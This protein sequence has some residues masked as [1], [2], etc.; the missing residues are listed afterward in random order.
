MKTWHPAAPAIL[1]AFHVGA[2]TS[3]AAPPADAHEYWLA[4]SRYDAGPGAALTVGG[5]A[6]TGFRGERKPWSPTHGVRFVV[7]ARATLDLRG[8]A[9]VGEEA[10]ARFAPSDRGGAL[11]GYVSDFTPV[12]LDPGAFDRY[13][14]DE[15][16]SLAQAARRAASARGAGARPGLERYRRCAKAWIAGDDAARATTPLGFPLEIV[17]GTIPGTGPTLDLRV[18]RDGRPAAGLLVKA[19]RAPLGGDGTPRADA[20]RDSMAVAFRGITDARGAVRVPVGGS[21]EWLISAVEMVRS[22]DAAAAEWE[23][24]WASLTFARP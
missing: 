21:G 19:W 2:M 12:T 11:F 5:M 13:L 8:V 6:G 14:A 23:S 22:A 9:E 4:P 18:L 3:L 24:T 17:P 7:R 10:W 20:T 16:L 1:L 15:G